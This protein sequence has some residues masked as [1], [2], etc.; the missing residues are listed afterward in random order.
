MTA[1]TNTYDSAADLSLGHVARVESF[2]ELHTELLDIHNAIEG[3]LTYVEDNLARDRAF[4]LVTDDYIVQVTDKLILVDTTAKNITITMHP[5]ADGIGLDYE[6]KQIAGDNE[7]LVIG[8]VI[9]PS[10]TAEPVDSDVDGITIDLLEAL[11]IKNDG[12]NWW[13]NN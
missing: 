4:I 7:T 3:T 9:P 2:E 1:P 10:L 8:S 5:A 12:S 11:P 13:I 6:I